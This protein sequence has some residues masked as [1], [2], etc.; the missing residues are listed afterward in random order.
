MLHDVGIVIDQLGKRSHTDL[1]GINSEYGAKF[2]HSCSFK[3]MNENL[4]SCE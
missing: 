4:P 3:E 2:G 1:A